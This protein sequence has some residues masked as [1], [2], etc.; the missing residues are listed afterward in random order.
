MCTGRKLCVTVFVVHDVYNVLL[1]DSQRRF[2]TTFDVMYCPISGSDV[3]LIRSVASF[4]SIESVF[5]WIDF[6]TSLVTRRDVTAPKKCA[7]KVKC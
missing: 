5:C 4:F 3:M 2:S 6:L 1:S 7:D